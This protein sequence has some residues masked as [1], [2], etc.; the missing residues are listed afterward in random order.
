MIFVNIESLILQWQ[1]TFLV[2]CL[3]FIQEFKKKKL[4]D[5]ARIL[6]RNV[7]KLFKMHYNSISISL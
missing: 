7:E 3:Y 1:Y 2:Q 4:D 5:S 6:F